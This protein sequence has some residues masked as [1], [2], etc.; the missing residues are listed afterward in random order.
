MAR[1]QANIFTILLVSSLPLHM[2]YG[3]KLTTRERLVTDG[4]AAI[5][6]GFREGTEGN[7]GGARYCD[8]YCAH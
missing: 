6:I 4:Q 5:C 2:V 3:L 1:L 7:Q 8:H